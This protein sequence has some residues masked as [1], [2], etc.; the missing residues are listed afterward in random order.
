MPLSPSVPPSSMPQRV[1]HLLDPFLFPFSSLQ[2][3]FSLYGTL[4]SFIFV[5]RLSVGSGASNLIRHLFSQVHPPLWELFLHNNIYTDHRNIWKRLQF[6][7]AF[8]QI[9]G[10]LWLCGRNELVCEHF[11][12]LMLKLYVNV[13][14]CSNQVFKDYWEKVIIELLFLLLMLYLNLK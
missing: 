4:L 6:K 1:Q 9:R 7:S 5:S 10:Y 14:L 2:P 13:K 8:P 3:S 11:S 12:T